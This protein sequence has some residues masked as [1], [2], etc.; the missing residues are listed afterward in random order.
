MNVGM[1]LDDY[2]LFSITW[3]VGVANI[4]CC[5]TVVKCVLSPALNINMGCTR[6]PFGNTSMLITAA[7]VVAHFGL[8]RLLLLV[9]PFSSRDIC[10]HL[11]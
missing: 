5:D 9:A 3:R 2:W 6:L 4:H 11:F 10:F 1:M 8:F 7:A